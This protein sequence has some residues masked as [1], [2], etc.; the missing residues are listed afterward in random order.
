MSNKQNNQPSIQEDKPPVELVSA[1]IVLQELV[2]GKG[3][4]TEK[5]AEDAL[6]YSTAV[7]KAMIESLTPGGVVTS[8][9]R[10]LRLLNEILNGADASAL[11][12]KKLKIDEG[13]L[14]TNKEQVAMLLAVLKT[15][16]LGKDNSEA[17]DV[18]VREIEPEL[19][20]QRKVSLV[21]GELTQGTATI[22]YDELMGTDNHDS[23][24]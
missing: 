23:F 3:F 24:N 10:K 9:S 8:D 7:R 16:E 14:E 11:S 19:Q 17:L 20:A 2:D 12:L 4:D 13:M 15:G 21:P 5:A 1:P 22:S 18:E 6:R